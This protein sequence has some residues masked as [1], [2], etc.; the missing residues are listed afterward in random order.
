MQIFVKLASSGSTLTLDVEPSDSVEIVKQ[1]IQDRGGA[2]AQSQTLIYKGKQLT[3]SSL[4]SDYGIEK[5]ATLSLEPCRSSTFTLQAS[6]LGTKPTVKL[7]R[8]WKNG[9]CLK[10]LDDKEDVAADAYDVCEVYEGESAVWKDR[11]FK[12]HIFH[13]HEK[14]VI[15]VL[16]RE[17]LLR[18]QRSSIAFLRRLRCIGA[19][20]SALETFARF[21]M[22]EDMD[23]LDIRILHDCYDGFIKSRA[24]ISSLTAGLES[25]DDQ[26][27][28]V[29]KEEQ[30]PTTEVSDEAA[31]GDTVVMRSTTV[32]SLN[33]LILFDEVRVVGHT[34]DSTVTEAEGEDSSEGAEGVTPPAPPTEEIASLPVYFLPTESQ[35]R[36]DL[37]RDRRWLVMSPLQL[38]TT[39]IV[40]CLTTDLQG[41]LSIFIG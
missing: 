41:N 28:F 13:E 10:D 19:G 33:P 34:D 36:Y 1:K 8:Y 39:P 6:G 20:L 18:S 7:L 21:F 4:L 29:D 27:L 16:L 12:N 11:P 23:A 2:L 35:M 25:F 17:R 9:R 37:A 40:P 38:R 31:A 30:V 22:G 24:Q 26:Y 15:L 5:E 14:L 32:R 3:D